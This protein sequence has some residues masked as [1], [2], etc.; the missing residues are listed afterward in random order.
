MEEVQHT[1]QTIRPTPLQQGTDVKI[2][3]Q[4][5]IALFLRLQR[6]IAQRVCPIWS[7]KRMLHRDSAPLIHSAFHQGILIE[8]INCGL[9]PPTLLTVSRSVRLILLPYHE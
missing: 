6:D 3:C 8:K 5:S 4:Q 2:K 1:M 7:D 9:G